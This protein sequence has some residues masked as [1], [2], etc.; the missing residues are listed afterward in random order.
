MTKI[1]YNKIKAALAE[2]GITNK[3][4][5]DALKIAP[6]TVSSWCTN[7]AQP[8][9]KRLFDVATFLDV[10]AGELLVSWRKRNI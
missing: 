10:E 2:K 5:A 3:E 6:E 7:T 1:N 4:L 8:S 9:I